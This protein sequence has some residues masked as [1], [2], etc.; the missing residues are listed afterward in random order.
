[1]K[2]LLTTFRYPDGRLEVRDSSGNIYTPMQSLQ[3]IEGIPS[4]SIP[5]IHQLPLP[6]LNVT[7]PKFDALPGNAKAGFFGQGGGAEKAID[8]FSGIFRKKDTGQNTFVGDLVTELAKQGAEP[9]S[10]GFASVEDPTFDPRFQQPGANFI[11]S[12]NTPSTASLPKWVLPVGIGLGVLS[13]SY[14]ALK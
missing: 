1:M 4:I 10:S 7:P 11:N 3:G 5:A 14:M 12:N 2:R 6:K 9:I 13:L 8:F